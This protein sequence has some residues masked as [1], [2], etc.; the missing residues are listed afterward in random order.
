M[1]GN[2]RAS[3]LVAARKDTCTY[4]S[5]DYF[6]VTDD[7]SYNEKRKKKMAHSRIIICTVGFKQ[8]IG[9]CGKDLVVCG[10]HGNYK[11]M[12]FE[13]PTVLEAWWDNLVR[14]VRGHN[15]RFL[16]GDFNMAVTR[17]L[18]KLR[19]RGLQVDCCAWY[20]WRHATIELHDQHLGFDS[21]AI[22]YIGGSVEVTPHWGLN[23]IPFLTAVADGNAGATGERKEKK[24]DV[25]EGSATPGQP[26]CCY[27][28]K[29][30][31]EADDE[32]D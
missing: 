26:W 17:V 19:S 25:Y 13:W 8:N 10:F 32:K 22:F 4:L 21:C 7:H 1:R 2:E 24:L 28:C 14:L 18:P 12:K 6:E 31:R 9:H 3:L 16:A 20:P 29:G 15:V 5:L 27:R 11:T 30:N 23:D